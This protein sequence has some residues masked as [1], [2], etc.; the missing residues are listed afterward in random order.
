MWDAIV[1]Y[2][3]SKGVEYVVFAAVL[4]LKLQDSAII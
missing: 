4:A 2:R 1:V 3:S